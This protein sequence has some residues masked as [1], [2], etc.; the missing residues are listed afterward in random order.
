MQPVVLFNGFL[1]PEDNVPNGKL[2][3]KMCNFGLMQVSSAR[4]HAQ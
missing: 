3:V 1:V 4:A 2:L